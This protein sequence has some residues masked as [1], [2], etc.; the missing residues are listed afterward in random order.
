MR[1]TQIHLNFIHQHI[2]TMHQQLTN[3][4]LNKFFS[5]IICIVYLH[6]NIIYTNTITHC[7]QHNTIA[8]KYSICVYLYLLF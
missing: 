1:K 8:Y 4:I 6:S 5:F 7:T 3:N 2:Q